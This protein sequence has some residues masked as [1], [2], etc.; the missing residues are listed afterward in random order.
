MTVTAIEAEI[1]GRCLRSG[2]QD[3]ARRFFREAAA[4]I[5]PAWRIAAGGGAGAAHSRAGSGRR[6]PGDQANGGVTHPRVV[7]DAGPMFAEFPRR[8]AA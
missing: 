8:A 2:R 6:P 1:L 5:E 7:I 4:A 3:L